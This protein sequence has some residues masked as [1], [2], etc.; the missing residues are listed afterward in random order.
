MEFL[1]NGF[2]LELCPG[3]FPLSTDSVALAHFVQ[4][5]PGDRV[6]DLGSGCGT[7]GLMLCSRC[8]TLQVTGVEIDENAHLQALKNGERNN[9]SQR[10]TSICADITAIPGQIVSGSFSVCISNPPYFN[11]GPDSKKTPVARKENGFSPE[12]L[13]SVASQ[14]LKYGGDFYMVHRPERLAEIFAKASAQKLEPKKLLLLRHRQDGPVSLVLVHCKKGGKP[15]LL[16]QE[17][18]LHNPDGSPSAYYN[19]L[20]HD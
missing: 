18:F 6:L 17:E 1:E 13:F 14:A 9:I 12:A 19:S 20:Y 10:F 11:G 8:D 15:G 5:R 3:A 4:C 7:L 2:T 16:W